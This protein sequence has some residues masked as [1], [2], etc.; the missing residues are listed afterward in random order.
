MEKMLNSEKSSSF[1]KICKRRSKSIPDDLLSFRFDHPDP[2]QCKENQNPDE[3]PSLEDGFNHDRIL[4]EVDEFIQK[5]KLAL[6]EDKCQA[7]EIPDCIESSLKMVESMIAR[8]DQREASSKFGQNEDEDASFFD[9]ISRLGKIINNL[10]GFGF[11]FE[12]ATTTNCY[13]RVGSVHHRALVLL[14]YEFRALL[15]N[16]K[17]TS[18]NLNINLD[19]TSN[20][21]TPKTPKQ[22]FFNSNQ[23]LESKAEELEFPCF[24][25]E[26]IS[27][28]NQIATA[29]V[30][31]GFE[32]ECLIAYS[33]LRLKALDI[34]LSKQGFE[35]LNTEDVQRMSWESLEEEISNWVQIVKHCSTNLFSAE[36]NLCNSIF[37]Q[38]PSIA[39]RL[40]IY[41][42]TAVIVRLLNFAN[43]VVL[44]KRYNSTEKLFKFLDIYE[45]LLDLIPGDIGDDP[46]ANDLLFETSVTQCRVG[47]AAVS[48]F[49]QLE[50]SIK[51]DNERIPVASGAVHPLTRWTMNYLKLACDYKDI[52]EQVFQ[53]H[54]Q[55][56]ESA[57]Q[58]VEEQETKN[59]MDMFNVEGSPKTSPFSVKLMM[60]M[61]LLDA[62]VE[63]KSMLYRDPALRYIFLMNNER[64]V[65]Q[66][67]K[68]SKE[69]YEMLGHTWSRKRTSVVRQ[70]HKNYQRETWSKVLQC[71]NHEG[72]QV[73]GKVSK[74]L[75]KERF[76]NF[77]NMF[78][79]ILKTQSTWVVSDDQLQS[80]LRVSISAVVI[81]AY[82]SFLGR[83]KSY[84]DHG[85][86]ADK[87]I[88]YQPED[89]EGLLEQLFDGNTVSM[90]RRRT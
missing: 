21:K 88:K 62:N 81:P 15:D 54:Y 10:D 55:M 22:S 37:S 74:A 5:L 67:I 73:Q 36:R 63:R 48:I 18:L 41:L 90:G 4:E 86:A 53:K 89:I 14:E 9:A 32:A 60:V 56:E 85:R 33:D 78:D 68:G 19:S 69:I 7:P 71:I 51:S 77:N 35:N 80:E 20:S 38:H 82:R 2:K 34:E 50:N 12:S 3:F 79:E 46:L 70:H 57:R 59:A 47:E 75:L 61:D 6:D 84:L 1:S 42:A 65:L 8:Y 27:T 31:E 24:S 87:Y 28:V 26:S 39:Q 64:Y 13:N 43:A 29:I 83:F 25:P 49:S 58:R 30:F 72:L 17:R 23:E 45:A 40:F 66:K 76:K 52:L 11:P 16:S 44:T